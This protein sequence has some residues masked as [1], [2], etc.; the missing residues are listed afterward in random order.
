VTVE[1]KA[2]VF[3]TYNDTLAATIALLEAD[4]GIRFVECHAHVSIRDRRRAFTQFQ[5]N[6]SVRVMVMLV[7][8]AAEGINLPAASHVIF[9]EPPPSEDVTTQ[10]I[11]RAHRIGQKKQVY[12][13][14]LIATGTVEEAARGGRGFPPTRVEQDLRALRPIALPPAPTDED[15]SSVTPGICTAA[16]HAVASRR[17]RAQHAAAIEEH[18]DALEIRCP[19][20]G[21]DGGHREFSWVPAVLVS[22]STITWTVNVQCDGLPLQHRFLF[23]IPLRDVRPANPT[24]DLDPD[25]VSRLSVL[26]I[27]EVS[28]HLSSDTT[29]TWHE[30]IVVGSAGLR[31]DAVQ[32]AAGVGGSPTKA[33]P[34]GELLVRYRNKEWNKRRTPT[35]TVGGTGGE[36]HCLD[37]RALTATKAPVRV[38]HSL[39]E[40]SWSEVFGVVSAYVTDALKSPNNRVLVAAARTLLS[41]LASS[42]IADV[43]GAARMERLATRLAATTQPSS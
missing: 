17:S 7:S 37:R 21:V 30:A 13:H 36:W 43:A 35:W 11:G 5:T 2:L 1:D 12:V 40:W 16:R 4:G 14:H 28:A 3:C 25:A 19:R 38:R 6:E 41:A 34:E 23:N 29:T 33:V 31:A 8:L 39:T 24:P 9:V 15:E 27:V 18:R 22:L 32:A 20:S 26:S 42:Q 10:A